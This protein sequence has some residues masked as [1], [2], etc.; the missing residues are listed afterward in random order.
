M[1]EDI[2][3]GNK[4]GNFWI[5]IKYDTKHP[6]LYLHSN[7]R[8]PLHTDGSYEAYPPELSFFFCKVKA[9]FGGATTFLDLQILEQ[10]MEMEC[11]SLLRRI[12][13]E[14][15]LFSKGNDF[16]KQKY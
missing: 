6:N 11:P 7:T 1:D 10:C 15:F 8:Q 14:S 13:S 2:E 12:K 9:K 16:K 3:T 4:N 5:D